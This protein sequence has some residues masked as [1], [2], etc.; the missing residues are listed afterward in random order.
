M[1]ET[2]FN[3]L[4]GYIEGARVVDLFAGSGALGLE[5][6]SRGAEHVSFI[7]L[8]KTAAKAIDSNL[9][10]LNNEPQLANAQVHNQSALTFLEQIE[11]KSCDILLLDPPFSAE[12]HNQ[13]LQLIE[14]SNIM[15]DSGLIYIEAPQKQPLILPSGWSKHREKSSG[16]V[17]FSLYKKEE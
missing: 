4:T 3:W 17:E 6:L 14:S 11:Q 10:V 7:E 13:I 8:D 12:L 16:Q 1:R 15:K 2:L 5:S 9:K